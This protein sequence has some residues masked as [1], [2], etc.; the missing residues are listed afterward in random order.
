M[1]GMTENL[2]TGSESPGI[3]A[4]VECLRKFLRDWS[5]GPLIGRG[6]LRTTESSNGEPPDLR[7]VQTV[8]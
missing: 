2:T 1:R 5:A 3:D 4:G 7:D 8:R 6:R